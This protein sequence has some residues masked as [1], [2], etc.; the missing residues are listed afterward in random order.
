MPKPTTPDEKEDDHHDLPT[1]DRASADPEVQDDSEQ[2]FSDAEMGSTGS[3]DI[4][5]VDIDRDDARATGHI[6]KSSSVAWAKRTAEECNQTTHQG[7]A[8]GKHD[9]GFTLSS[10]YA[11]D[12]DVE[13]FDVNN[14][15]PY[16]WPDPKTADRLVDAYFD[17]VHNA[18]PIIDKAIFM[19][20][21]K[22]FI[23][24]SNNLAL[25]DL[26]WL[27]TVNT[28]FAISSVY[29]DLCKNTEGR[30]HQD[31]LIYCARAKMLYL[32]QE[33]LYQD[34]RMSTTC[35]LGLMCLYFVTTCRLNRSVKIFRSLAMAKLVQGLDI[36]WPS[37]KKCVNAWLT[38]AE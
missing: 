30:T 12:A 14:I 11:E 6:G 7:T 28:V 32:G 13:Y 1:S 26:I 31:H 5:N 2:S 36:L 19:S 3:L 18:M 29:F 33:L 16:G 9:T 22:R 8:V 20:K 25:E 23:R 21:Y 24:G 17:H 27:A 35:A 15:D 4:I 38:R 37:D 34:A 10:Y